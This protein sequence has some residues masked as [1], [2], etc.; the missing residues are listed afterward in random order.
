MD[1]IFITSIHSSSHNGKSNNEMN[2]ERSSKHPLLSNLCMSRGDGD[3]S[4]STNSLLQRGV[5]SKAK[6]VLVKNIQEL[7]INLNFPKYIKVADLGCSCGQNTFLALSEIINTIIVLCQQRNKNL[8]EIECCLNDLPS[9]DFNT[10]FK[11]IHFFQNKNLKIKESCFISGV[12]GSFYSRLFPRKSLHLVHSSYALHWLFKVPEGLEK[13]KMS[14]YIITSSPISTYKAYLNQFQRDFTT[15]LKLRSEEMVSN[16]CMVLTL[17]GR[18][19]TD[20]P[21]HRDCCY[22]WTL[23]SKSLRNLVNEGVLN[24][25]KVNSFKIPFYDPNEEELKYIIG[26]EGSFEIID[27]ETYGFDLRYNNEDCGN[28]QTNKATS[29]HKEAS[30]VRAV[31]ETILIAHFGNDFNMDTYFNKY[32]HHVSQHACCVNKTSLT[33]VVS[34]VR[35]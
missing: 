4:Y 30:C 8:P 11:F 20:D 18:N 1:T 10:T 14:V 16:G 25:S 35:K 13:N 3:K 2:E 23:L 32:A 6:S 21:L 33:L 34:L 31:T 27:L 7:I 29:G 15:F 9:N 19:T 17:L 24:E 28:L 22:F 5:L 26:K 12:P